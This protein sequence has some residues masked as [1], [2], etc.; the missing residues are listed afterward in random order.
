MLNDILMY[1]AV[2]GVAAALIWYLCR[3]IRMSIR[4]FFDRHGLL[5]KALS[6]LAVVVEFILRWAGIAVFILT[7]LALYALL[8]V[9]VCLCG[10]LCFGL[11]GLGRLLDLKLLQTAGQW[12]GTHL[13][14]L[15]FF[16]LDKG[17]DVKDRL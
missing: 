11:Y 4:S 14:D 13:S 7:V 2:Y 15:L 16:L 8:L 12:G 3:S 10:L 9:V 1:V 6:I 17:K 5:L